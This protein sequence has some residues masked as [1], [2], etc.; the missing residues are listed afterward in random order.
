[1]RVAEPGGGACCRATLVRR[2]RHSSAAPRAS[3]TA[4]TTHACSPRRLTLSHEP[5]TQGVAHDLLDRTA[6]LHVPSRT[7]TRGILQIHLTAQ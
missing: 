3:D 2:G 7:L 4:Y 1:M 5:Q 6:P